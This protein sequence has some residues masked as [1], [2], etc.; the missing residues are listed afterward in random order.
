MN[1]HKLNRGFTLVELLIVIVVIAILAS[2]TLVAYSGIRERAYNTVTTNAASAWITLLSASYTL[3]GTISI[4]YTPAYGGGVCLGNPADYSGAV[5][6][7]VA[8]ECY[9]DFFADQA[10]Y[11]QLSEAGV[12]SMQPHAFDI[13]NGQYTR[14]IQYTFEGDGNAYLHYDLLGEQ[15]DC[16]LSGSS[17]IDAEEN[18]PSTDCQVNITSKLGGH[19][20]DF[21][22]DS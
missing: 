14:G 7:L 8:G 17:I 10:M 21:E 13:G 5:G 2:I 16:G 9:H 20:I 3:N 22:W 6:D 11:D 4:D 12:A 18:S 1:K 15:D 19:P